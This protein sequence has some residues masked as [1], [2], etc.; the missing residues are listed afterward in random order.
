MTFAMLK[1]RVAE[2]PG[3]AD[4]KT[5]CATHAELFLKANAGDDFWDEEEYEQL[6]CGEFDP[7]TMEAVR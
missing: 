5:R 3:M 1:Q 7:W 6:G 4:T 2:D